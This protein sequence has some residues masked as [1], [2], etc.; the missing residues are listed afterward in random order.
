MLHPDCTW[1]A[2]V[3]SFL[4]HS[5]LIASIKL[6]VD[7]LLK[8]SC[9]GQKTNS[10]ECICALV[11]AAPR[12]QKELS[13]ETEYTGVCLSNCWCFI[14]VLVNKFHS[15]LLYGIIGCYSLI[16]K[17]GASLILSLSLLLP[18]FFYTKI[19]FRFS[20]LGWKR[21]LPLRYRHFLILISCECWIFIEKDVIKI[22]YF[23]ELGW[24]AHPSPLSVKFSNDCAPLYMSVIHHTLKIFQ[25]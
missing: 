21:H 6:R 17:D 5:H 14:Y 7:T 3:L 15:T 18:Y 13:T 9:T 25:I 10:Q 1:S 4:L 11:A 24:N 22:F 8:V 23:L 20:G 19:N 12:R 2:W 16:H